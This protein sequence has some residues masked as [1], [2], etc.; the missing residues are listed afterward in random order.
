MEITLETV[1]PESFKNIL[2]HDLE[3][4]EARPNFRL[5]CIAFAGSEERARAFMAAPG[6]GIGA[7]SKMVELPGSTVRHYIRLGLVEPFEVNGK[8]RCQYWNPAQVESVRW[9]SELG[10]T[11]EEILQRKISARARHPGLKLRDVIHIHVGS[12]EGDGLAMF[13]QNPIERGVGFEQESSLWISEEG[14]EDSPPFPPSNTNEEQRLEF[15]VI[16][17]ELLEEY[18]AARNKLE[19]KKRELNAR[20]ARTLEIEQKFATTIN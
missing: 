5:N 1:S 14:P 18:R 16:A 4:F 7:F 20:I 12:F 3:T 9:W 2:K 15:H 11:L 19:A 6:V 8:Y 13:R 17:A 10:L